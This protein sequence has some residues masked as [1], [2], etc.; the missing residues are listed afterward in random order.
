L[1]PLFSIILST[2]NRAYVLWRAI[3]SVLAQTEPRWELLVV[4]DGSTDDTPRLMEEFHDPR[5][6]TLPTAHH[7]PLGGA[8]FRHLPVIW[9]LSCLPRL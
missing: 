4:D 9:N 3:L 2:Y 6:R 5:I 8:Q 1:P 7:G